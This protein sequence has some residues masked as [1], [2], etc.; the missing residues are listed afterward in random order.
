MKLWCKNPLDTLMCQ[1]YSTKLPGGTFLYKQFYRWAYQIPTIKDD[2]FFKLKQNMRYKL[3]W[4]LR[5]GSFKSLTQEINR[6]HFFTVED[7]R[8]IDEN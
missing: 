4:Y 7:E 5:D 6:L 2:T 1:Y 8:D 3:F